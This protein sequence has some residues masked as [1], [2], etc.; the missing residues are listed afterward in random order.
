[1]YLSNEMQLTEHFTLNEF[2]R[3]QIATRFKIDNT[4]NNEQI[5]N[6][7]LLCQNFM[8]PLRALIRAPIVITSGYRCKELNKRVGGSPNS[9]HLTGQACDFY[10]PSIPVKKLFS[11]SMKIPVFDQL[12]LEYDQWIHV[13]YSNK[14]N[15]RESLI[16]P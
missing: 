14:L 16:L 2:T 5:L 15:R 12:I 7:K 13:S 4:P 1:V 11:E 6:L 8:E 3:S 10:C 9:Q